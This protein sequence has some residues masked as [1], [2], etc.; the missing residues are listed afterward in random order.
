MQT[1]IATTLDVQ[2]RGQLQTAVKTLNH[3]IN[4]SL[5]RLIPKAKAGDTDAYKRLQ[6]IAASTA[7]GMRDILHILDTQTAENIRATVASI[8][9]DINR[10]SEKAAAAA[11]GGIANL[12][13][14]A[15]KGSPAVTVA[16]LGLGGYLVWRKLK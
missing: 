6:R 13:M 10:L 2:T 1:R 5:T 3:I 11:S 15:F 12:L 9:K 16:V 14:G 7:D 4:G 8:E